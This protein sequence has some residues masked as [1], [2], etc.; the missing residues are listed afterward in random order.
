MIDKAAEFDGTRRAVIRGA[1]GATAYGVLGSLGGRATANAPFTSLRIGVILRGD[2]KAGGRDILLIPGLAS[3]PAIWASLVKQLSGH[4]LHLVHVNG[5]AKRPAGAN[6]AGP[7]LDPLTVDLARYINTHGLRAPVIIGH[8][9]GGTVALMLG[10]RPDVKPARIMVVDMLPDGAAMLGGTAQ[11]Y[12]Y[13]AT[14]LNGYFTGTKAGR[15]MLTDMVRQTPGGRDSDPRVIAQA[16][17][18]LAQTDLTAKLRALACPLTV[19][20]ALPGTPRLD[21][22]QLQRFKAAYAGVKAL[23]LTG[24]GPSAHQIMLDQPEKFTAAVRKFL[25]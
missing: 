23:T 21:T 24:I 11:G 9:M 15:Q 16:L 22:A 18:E 6:A 19:V 10:L 5:F 25:G 8:S 20:P 13:L 2:L 12:G 4:R 17:T 3:S 14:Q 1:L 7:L